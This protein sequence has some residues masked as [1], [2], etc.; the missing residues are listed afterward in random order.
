ML[1]LEDN[2]VLLVVVKSCK[3]IEGRYRE[4]GG[5]GAVQCSAVQRRSSAESKVR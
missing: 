3:G 4:E 5:S 2:G 1:M